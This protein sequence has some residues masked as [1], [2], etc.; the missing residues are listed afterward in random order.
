MK[1]IEYLVLLTE[2]FK[3]KQLS[4][5]ICWPP[6]IMAL[7]RECCTDRIGSTFGLRT[8]SWKVTSWEDPVGHDFSCSKAAMRRLA[9]ETS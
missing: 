2:Q 5:E 3:F 4:G 6:E 7:R 8:V 9:P 1:P